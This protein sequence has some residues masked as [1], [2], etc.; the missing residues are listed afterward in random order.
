MKPM[1]KFFVWCAIIGVL[2]IMGP[3]VAAH[4]AH[5]IIHWWTDFFST[6]KGGEANDPNIKNLFS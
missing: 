3:V 1:N 5:D 6:L 2:A 4:F